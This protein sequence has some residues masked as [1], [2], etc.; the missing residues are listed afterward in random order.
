[1]NEIKNNLIFKK[2][3]VNLYQLILVIIYSIIVSSNSEIDNQDLDESIYSYI[4]LKIEK[5][6]NN[7]YSNS[8]SK[9]PKIVY[10]NENKQIVKQNYTFE[11]SE[12]SVI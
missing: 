5:G 9:N 12:N 11:E 10:I 8:Y 3:K 1:M 6:N 2:Q 4:T 7:I